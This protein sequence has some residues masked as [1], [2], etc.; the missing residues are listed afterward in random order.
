MNNC[1]SSANKLLIKIIVLVV[2]VT[3]HKGYSVER[4]IFLNIQNKKR[5]L[6]DL[7]NFLFPLRPNFSLAKKKKNSR[8]ISNEKYFHRGK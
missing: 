5:N 8:I 1:I 3:S 7:I 2:H 4:N 6:T